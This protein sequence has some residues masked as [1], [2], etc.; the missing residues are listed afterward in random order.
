MTVSADATTDAHA[1]AA[2]TAA[3]APTAAPA[4]GIAPPHHTA[5]PETA[6]PPEAVVPP[7]TAPQRSAR[8]RRRAGRWCWGTWLVVSASVAW[9]GFVVAQLALAGRVWWWSLPELVPPLMF[10]VV[11][12]LL[13]AVAPLARPARGRIAAVL[14]GALVLGWELNGVNAAALWHRPPPA[15]A[16]AL[17]VFSFNTWYW[18]QPTAGTRLRPPP[19]GT[20]AADRDA[21]YAYLHAQ[22]ADVYLLQEYVYVHDDWSPIRVADRDR[23]EAEFPDHHLAILGEFVTLSRYPIRTRTGVDLRPWLTEEHGELPPP[24]SEL[25]EYHTTKAFRTDI[26]VGGRLVSLYN[27]HIPPPDQGLSL[28]RAQSRQTMRLQYDR[29]NASF[30]A[31]AADV[32]GNPHPTLVAGDFNSSPAI[33]IRHLLPDRLTD[34]VAAMGSPYPATWDERWPARLWRIDWAFTTADLTVHEYDLVRAGGLSD[35]TGIRLTVSL[36]G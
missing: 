19:G 30:R 8:P 28:H 26:E 16:Q 36:T 2:R 29:R 6:T 13:L 33:G 15:P 22:D 21:L 5:P 9:L 20:P 27:T 31:L 7:T 24:D 25:P 4:Q 12:L 35:H 17:T 32:A 3:P 10:L 14:V 23:I 18:D 34:P 1:G 11:P